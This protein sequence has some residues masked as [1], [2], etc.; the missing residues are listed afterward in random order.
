[1]QT[2]PRRNARNLSHAIYYLLAFTRIAGPE[3][4]GTCE[5]QPRMLT[6]TKPFGRYR[7]AVKKHGKT[8]PEWRMPIMYLD[9][10]AK[11]QREELREKCRNFINWTS[12]TA[13][14]SSQ[15]CG[16]LAAG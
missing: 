15:R 2:A 5:D 9:H 16:C 13:I 10:R 7:V 3:R 4:G 12:Q 1:M 8:A 11:T 6:I 14:L